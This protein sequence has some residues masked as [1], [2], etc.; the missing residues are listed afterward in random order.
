MSAAA[1][2]RGGETVEDMLDGEISAAAVAR[3]ERVI[4][5]CLAAV[6]FTTIIDFMV[7]MPLC[8]QLEKALNLGP[9]RFGMVVAAYTYAAGLA[10]LVATVTLDRFARRTAFLTVFAGFI[11]GTLACEAA[12]WERTRPCS[13]WPRDWGL[14]LIHI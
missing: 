10:G 6:H 14:S 2:S 12:S 1:G 13:T 4:L 3:R 7:V 11:L 5:F 9:A 8:P